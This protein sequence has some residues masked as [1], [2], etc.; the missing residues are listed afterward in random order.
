MSDPKPLKPPP[1]GLMR[2]AGMGVELAGTILVGCLLGY[3]IDRRFGTGPW[4]LVVCACI[5][6][7]GGL[8]NMIRQAVHEMLR[9]TTRPKPDQ[10]DESKVPPQ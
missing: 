10:D 9:Q 3:W 2:L 4:G 8:Y 6:V 5:G 1:A 7:V